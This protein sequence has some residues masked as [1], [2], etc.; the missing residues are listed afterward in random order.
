MWK[1]VKIDCW[2]SLRW[3]SICT[4]QDQQRQLPFHVKVKVDCWSLFDDHWSAPMR[5]NRGNCLFMH[6]WKL[7]CYPLFDNHWSA[8]SPRIKRWHPFTWRSNHLFMWRGICLFMHRGD[9]IFTHR[10][11]C[12]FTYRDCWSSVLIVNSNVNSFNTNMQ[13]KWIFLDF[14]IS[15]WIIHPSH[16]KSTE[17]IAFSCESEKLTVDPLTAYYWFPLNNQKLNLGCSEVSLK[18]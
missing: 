6:K 10:G 18:S 1:M 2:S 14:V 4:P 12:L 16:P 11:N 9:H 3:L 7:T 17:A 15:V 8:P 5:I 13:E